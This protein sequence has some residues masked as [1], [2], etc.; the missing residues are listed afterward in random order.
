METKSKAMRVKEGITKL[1]VPHLDGE[2]VFAHPKVGFGTYTE[3]GGE[4]S[5]QGLTRPTMAQTASLVYAIFQDR[6][7]KYSKEIGRTLEDRWF[8][9]FTG[10]RYSETDGGVYIEDD[11][12][13][14]GG[15]FIVDSENN[16][17]K[18]LEE[19]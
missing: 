7:N 15:R 2:I 12:E 13:I 5:S 9:I 4:I 19:G 6:D 14:E 17:F 1:Y 10:S 18:R 8:W 11:P 16:L 3:V